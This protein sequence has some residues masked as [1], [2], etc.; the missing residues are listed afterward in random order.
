MAYLHCHSCDW[1]QDDF[2]DWKWRW[3]IWKLR[4]LGYTPLA[5]ILED[6]RE[7]AKPRYIHYKISWFTN[8]HGFQSFK[9]HSWHMLILMIKHDFEQIITMK[10]W[11]WKSWQKHKMHATCPS[12]GARDFDID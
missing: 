5:L 4:S 11:T 2:W 12:C 9:I 7:Y 6:I 1:S 8:G 10:W 3:R